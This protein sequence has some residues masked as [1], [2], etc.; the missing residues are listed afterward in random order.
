MAI[1][2]LLQ[3]RAFGPKE[4]DLMVSAFEQALAIFAL[5]RRDDPVTERVA[6]IIIKVAQTGE[7]DPARICSQAVAELVNCRAA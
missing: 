1:Y 2:R 4:I 6:K 3:N 5:K 7:R